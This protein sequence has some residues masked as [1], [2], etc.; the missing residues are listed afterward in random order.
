MKLESFSVDSSYI[1]HQN[2]LLNICFQSLELEISLSVVIWQN[3]DA[4]IQ[5]SR[6]WVG[7]VV[8]EN[9]TVHIS[10]DDSE[11]FA[12]HPFRSLIAML[13][14]QAVMNVAIL[15]VKIIQNYISVA[16]MTCSKD[17]YLKVFA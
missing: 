15:W 12:V 9:H 1:F 13:A 8:N 16:A 17:D 3:R 2:D 5:L 10:I 11:I 6:I 4:I 7:S 14:E